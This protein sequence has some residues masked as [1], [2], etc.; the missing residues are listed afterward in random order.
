MSGITLLV[1]L[2]IL[3]QPVF[4]RPDVPNV[5]FTGNRHVS[6][7]RLVDAL[8]LEPESFTE[9]ES[10]LAALERVLTLYRDLGYL[11]AKAEVVGELTQLAHLVIRV[12][13]G[14]KY[15]VGHVGM[16]GN[17]SISDNLIL[18]AM[19]TRPGAIFAQELF[20]KDM[21]HILRLYEN[22]GFPFVQILPEDF[23]YETVDHKIR[24]IL[25]ITE[26]P[27]VRFAG[28]RVEGS[29]ISKPQYLARESGLRQGQVY[30]ALEL[31]NARRRLERL[32]FLAGVGDFRLEP[33]S[34]KEMVWAAVEVKE[35]AMNTVHGILGYEPGEDGGLTGLL[36]INLENLTGAGRGLK[37]R[38]Q[39]TSPLTSWLDLAYRE[40]FLLSYD[41]GLEVSFSHQIRDTSFTKS[42]LSI[43]GETRSGTVLGFNLGL[44]FDRVLPGS[45]PLPNSRS[46]GMRTGIWVDTRDSPRFPRKGI[47]YTLNAE[48]ALRMNSTTE[49]VRELKPTANT[50]KLTF[51]FIHHVP[52]LGGQSFFAAVHG[53]E[54]YSSEKEVLFHD[55][56]FL[57]GANSVRGYRE[58]QFAGSRVAWGNMEYRFRLGRGSHL[59]P[60]LDVGYYESQITGSVIG[61]GVGLLLRKGMAGVGLDYGLAKEDK[62]LDGKIHLR[63][64]GQF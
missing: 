61:Y 63:L 59:Y 20:L 18:S 7:Q 45:F 49:L 6:E 40:P 26:G 57:G 13:E 17:E 46:Y 43:V 15:T 38:W 62:P 21:E 1:L 16:T 52:S 27:K 30:S 19:D 25:R 64:T 29:K 35:G 50:G 36:T 53:R 23:S 14:Q 54:A 47:F 11:F 48:Y 3:G 10:V 2:S 51:D 31:E 8:R 12:E 58:E 39:R 22:N 42:S 34:S 28:V 24:V 44:S 32:S 5:E 41:V 4:P 55:Y 33:T 56:F 60:F 9:P 37:A